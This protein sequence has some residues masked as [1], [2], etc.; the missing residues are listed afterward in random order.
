MPRTERSKATMRLRCDDPSDS[1]IVRYTNEGEPFREG[2]Q[3]G[4]E[5]EDFKKEV[6]VMLEDSEARRLRDFLI[7]HYPIDGA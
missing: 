4:I 5:N 7:E 6:T 1:F 3:I 2:I